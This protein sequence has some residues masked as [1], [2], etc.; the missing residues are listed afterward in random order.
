M[1]RTSDDLLQAFEL[2]IRKPSFVVGN[3][4]RY[5]RNI[6]KQTGL[7]AEEFDRLLDEHRNLL[8]RM[9][10]GAWTG[11]REEVSA[12]PLTG[13]ETDD[14]ADELL[15]RGHL[16]AAAMRRASALEGKQRWGFK[17]LGDVIHAKQYASAFP[18]AQ[19]ILLVRDPRDHAL[20][21]MKLNDQRKDR[22][23][24]LFYESYRDVALGWLQTIRDGRL[25][26]EASGLDYVTMRYEDLVREP[27]TEMRRL[28]EMLGIDLV[29]AD[30]FYKAEYIEAHT[31]RFKH[32]DNL[33]NPINADSVGKWR[34]K[35]SSE[36]AGV[37]L[38]IAGSEM[39]YW[40]YA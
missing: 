19:V 3:E 33:K 25:A 37:F 4:G 9:N 20:S 38:E 35:M 27:K 26:L 21:V 28:E 5:T 24:P 11:P 22:G 30:T 32:H 13:R 10:L 7:P 17:I 12:E 36:E 39:E 18:R 23:Q 15:A 40:G 14:F 29:N 16:I 2:H 6:L 34:S 8:P 31:R 1:L